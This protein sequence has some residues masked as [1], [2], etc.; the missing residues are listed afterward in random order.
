M[1]A[2]CI[3]CCPL[4]LAVSG[5]ETLGFAVGAFLVIGLLLTCMILIT[6]AKLVS[7]AICKIEINEDPSQTFEVEGGQ[8]LLGALTTHGF[9]IPSPCGGKATCKQCKVQV[10]EG[11]G[12]PLETD[13]ATFS[14]KEIQ[15]GWRLS[16]QCKLKQDI[17]IHLEDSLAHV[18]TWDVEVLSNENVATFIKELIVKIPAEVKEM[19][20]RSGAYLQFHV[21]PFQTNT[22]DWKKTMD[23]RYYPDWE[24]F[25]MFGRFLDFSHIPEGT[26]RAY[27]MASYP[28]EGK[29][30][31]F[32][33]RIAT[34]PF[35]G[36]VIDEKIPWGICSSYVFSL[37]A[38]DKMHLSGPY[39]ESYMIEDD[40]P[41]FFLIGGAGSSFGRSHAL[42]LFYTAKTKR[43]VSFWYGARSLKENIYEKE[44]QELEKKYENFSYHL[45]LSEPLEEDLQGG[46]PKEDPVKTNYLYKAFELGELQK[47]EE[48]EESLYYVCGPPLHNQSVM[49]LLDNYGVPPENI[50]L[51][52]FGS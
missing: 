44:Y 3:G 12:E 39:G 48:P 52:D 15:Q 26:I 11:G 45:V 8:T 23:P 41:V 6:K 42:H 18:S 28:A 43:K 9:P 20:Y 38:G 34:P 46:W 49:T 29:I 16:C 50:V 51:D 21:P 33:V 19:E 47:M 30:I 1:K 5:I 22:D 7:S 4:F 36:E 2:E 14:H 10:K 24:K 31:R 40:R 37:Q 13:R 17:K 32:N 35:I 25:T 27:S